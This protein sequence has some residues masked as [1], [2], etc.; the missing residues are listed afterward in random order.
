MN[1]YGN[2]VRRMTANSTLVVEHAKG[3]FSKW[4]SMHSRAKQQTDESSKW[5]AFF[6]VWRH[7]VSTDVPPAAEKPAVDWTRFERFARAFR[8][9]YNQYRQSGA[10]ANVWQV[11]GIGHDELRNSQALAWLL[12]RYGDHGQGSAIL[13]RLVEAVGAKRHMDVTPAVVREADYS[14][15]TEVHPLGDRESRVDIEIKSSRFLIF[16]EV[17]VRAPESSDDQ[18]KRYTELARQT[19]AGLPSVVLFLTPEGRR[20]DDEE[21]H[22]AVISVSWG[23]VANILT[24]YASGERASSFSGQL[25]L[26]FA[27]H[28]R[29][30]TR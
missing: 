18:L 12:D 6:T 19:A 16:I 2:P 8:A 20:P 23:E 30:L 25:L 28:A 29:S 26:Q 7:V 15:R 3:F 9:P 5:K 14:T 10:M 13:E 21:L 1:T 4:Q 17:K 24:A 22:D 11:A 27:R